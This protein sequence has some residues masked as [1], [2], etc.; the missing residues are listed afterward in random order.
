M[1]LDRLRTQLRDNLYVTW[2]TVEPREGRQVDVGEQFDMRIV[3][4]NRFEDGGPDFL[5]V[6]LA[7]RET[8]FA[9][10]VDQ[11]GPLHLVERLEPGA[12]AQRVVRFEATAAHP[13]GDSAMEP[14]A[15]VRVHAR[16]DLRAWWDVETEVR[17]LH[18]QI[19]GDVEPE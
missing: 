9:R 4:K 19:H 10:P 6:T 8:P 18:A 16:A 11:N 2:V 1:N 13:E 5:D 12:T 17:L 14:V 3:V 15:A 7:V